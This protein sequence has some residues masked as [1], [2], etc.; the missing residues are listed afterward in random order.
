[1]NREELKDS[2]SIL[3]KEVDNLKIQNQKLKEELQSQT[4][5]AKEIEEANKLMNL[6]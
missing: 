1:M 5:Y 4:E 6:E 3:N 2:E